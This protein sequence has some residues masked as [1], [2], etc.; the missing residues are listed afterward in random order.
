MAGVFRSDGLVH[1]YQIFLILIVVDAADTALMNS[2]VF[3]H[4]LH[5]KA[6]QQTAQPLRARAAAELLRYTGGIPRNLEFH[7]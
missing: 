1:S 5:N 2:Q 3:R 6:L 4:H 7:A